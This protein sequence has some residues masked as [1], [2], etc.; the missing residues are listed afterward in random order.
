MS[1]L[2]SRSHWSHA[3][4]V[5]TRAEEQSLALRLEYSF[6]HRW[7]WIGDFSLISGGIRASNSA[8]APFMMTPL[9]LERSAEL[10]IL[11]K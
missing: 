8:E 9:I 5:G 4:S 1:I 7:C 3:Y 6:S 11:P 10:E 2:L